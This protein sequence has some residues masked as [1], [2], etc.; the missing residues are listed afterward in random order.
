MLIFEPAKRKR[1]EKKR[2]RHNKQLRFTQPFPTNN[3][4][5]LIKKITQNEK[6]LLSTAPAHGHA[7]SPNAKTV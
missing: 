5:Q 3:H 6:E 7:R 1:Y 2:C 4:N